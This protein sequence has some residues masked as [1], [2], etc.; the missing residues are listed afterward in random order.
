MLAGLLRHHVELQS[1]GTETRDPTGASVP[2][3]AT[4]AKRWTNIK[5][6]RGTEKYEAQQVEGKTAFKMQMR[7][8]SGIDQ[9]WR[10]KYGDRIFNIESIV[11]IAERRWG[12]EL[13]CVEV[14]GET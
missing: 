7:F 1:K 6:L 14:N 9:T 4:Q 5:P 2:G 8:Y 10:I 3:W 11:N 12:L 13:E